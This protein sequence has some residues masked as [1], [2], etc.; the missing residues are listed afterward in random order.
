MANRKTDKKETLTISEVEK[1]AKLAALTLDEAEKVKFQEQLGLTLDYIENLSKLDVN[2]VKPT[3][4]TTNA[5]NVSFEDGAQPTRTFT[6]QEALANASNP[7]AEGKFKVLRILNK[8][9]G[10]DHS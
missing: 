4:H 1:M 5:K 2:N 9:N 10:G 7:P 8:D 3:S 6:Q